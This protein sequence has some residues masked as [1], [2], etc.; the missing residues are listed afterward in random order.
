MLHLDDTIVPVATSY[1]D[2]VAAEARIGERTIEEIVRL[3]LFCDNFTTKLEGR[4]LGLKQEGKLHLYS[5]Q[6]PH[7]QNLCH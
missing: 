5:L 1:D 6:R 3:K 7:V 4:R 2:L